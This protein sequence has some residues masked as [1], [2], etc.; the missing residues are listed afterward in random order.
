LSEKDLELHAGAYK[1]PVHEMAQKQQLVEV[2]A[3][4]EQ[5]IVE[6]ANLCQS[7]KTTL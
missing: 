5:T 4:F 7:Y 6:Q 2:W 1:K 3:D